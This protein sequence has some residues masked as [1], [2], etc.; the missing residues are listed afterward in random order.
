MLRVFPLPHA[1]RGRD[2]L[3][4]NLVEGA[5]RLLSLLLPERLERVTTLRDLLPQA[6]RYLLRA[7]DRDVRRAPQPDLAPL[8]GQ[9]IA[10]DETS[11]AALD[12]KDQPLADGV[13]PVR[14][15]RD[16]PLLYALRFCLGHSC[17]L[18]GSPSGSPTS[19]AHFGREWP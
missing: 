1:R 4:K 18:I 7:G 8:A 19:V 5:R 13:L 12:A 10:E 11:A 15:G 17:L 16:I 6:Q 3:R 9:L 2:R 14:K